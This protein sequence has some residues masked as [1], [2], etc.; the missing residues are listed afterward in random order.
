MRARQKSSASSPLC[1]CFRRLA[2]PAT[3]LP[4]CTQHADS[5]FPSDQA[6]QRDRPMFKRRLGELNRALRISSDKAGLKVIAADRLKR[7]LEVFYIERE[8]IL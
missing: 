6:G 5:P 2:L 1:N 3:G 7:K 8:H 4:A